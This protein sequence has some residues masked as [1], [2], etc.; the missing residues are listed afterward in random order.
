M[1]AAREDN[2]LDFA[3]RRAERRRLEQ[4]LVTTRDALLLRR[5]QALL[6]CDEQDE[7]AEIAAR[8]GVSRQTIYNWIAR[9]QQRRGDPVEQRLADGVRTGR[10]P[11]VDGRTDAWIEE[12]IE[13]D[14]RDCG[15][16][17]TVWTAPLL[18]QYLEDVQDVSVSE[19]SVRRAIDRLGFRWKHPRYRLSLR[20]ATW[21]QAKGGCSE[22][23]PG[24]SAP[25]F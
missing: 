14:P 24:A 1:S 11:L 23:W 21:R 15:Y 20:P 7:V 5:A 25:S 4:L 19:D 10:P 13:G 3:L 2:R 9:C 18:R 22:A 8:L 6:W 17:A 16:A 12:V